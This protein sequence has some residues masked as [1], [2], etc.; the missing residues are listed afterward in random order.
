MIIYNMGNEKSIITLEK[1]TINQLRLL[2]K[3]HQF[4]SYNEL[5]IGI[6]EKY[7][8]IFKNSVPIQFAN[9]YLG[10]LK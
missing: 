6:I 2:K 1:E 5:V 9:F 10:L 4:S 3:K 8:D 7:A